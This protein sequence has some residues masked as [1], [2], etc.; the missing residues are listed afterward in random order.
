MAT[1]I[2]LIRFYERT[3]SRRLWWD[4]A[5]A[6]IGLIFINVLMAALG[7]DLENP[8]KR[9][10]PPPFIPI[11]IM[12]SVSGKH[13]QAT[14]IAL[15]YVYAQC[16]YAVVWSARLSILYTIIRLS[17]GTLRLILLYA[18]AIFLIIWAVLF[19]Q[20]WWMCEKE[21]GWKDKPHPQCNLGMEVAV[22][23]VITEIL[24]D[25][26]LV[27]VPLRLVWKIKLARSQKIR[28][29]AV[30]STTIISTTV[31]LA[32]A[33]YLVKMGGTSESLSGVVEC[34]I[35]LIVASLSVI[36]ALIFRIST[37]EQSPS[38]E[39]E[40]TPSI[41]TFGGTY[42]HNIQPTV[43]IRS[44]GIPNEEMNPPTIVQ[45]SSAMNQSLG[46]SGS[47][48]CLVDDFEHQKTKTVS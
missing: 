6:G 43:S 28:V 5:W 16:F 23:Q 39:M 7:V 35:S 48:H 34:S 30:F 19:A 12:E 4:D 18:S 11:S 29:N 47:T 40:T 9:N 33:Y 2:T 13:S 31:S 1:I 25:A 22:A 46:K 42:R 45:L 3:R 15:Y 36:V 37:E 21:P 27:F 24:C 32:H 14:Q 44:S 38:L 17:T 10:T 41:I 8:G 26:F 20:V